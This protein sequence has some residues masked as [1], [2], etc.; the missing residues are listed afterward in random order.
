MPPQE[1]RGSNTTQM[2]RLSKFAQGNFIILRLSLGAMLIVSFKLNVAKAITNPFA[3]SQLR[4]FQS[5]NSIP[6]IS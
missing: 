1:K 6:P 2:R 5:G 4:Y 3:F